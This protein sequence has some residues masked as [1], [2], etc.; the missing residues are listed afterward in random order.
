MS[1]SLNQIN[2]SSSFDLISNDETA[3]LRIKEDINFTY[4]GTLIRS[5]RYGLAQNLLHKINKPSDTPGQW[6]W[7]CLRA[8]LMVN[9]KE[10]KKCKQYLSDKISDRKS[11]EDLVS[12]L[13]YVMWEEFL[14][15][16]ESTVERSLT[17]EADVVKED[18]AK[19]IFSESSEDIEEIVPIW[20]FKNEIHAYN[21]QSSVEMFQGIALWGTGDKPAFIVKD[22][23]EENRINVLPIFL[24]E[25]INRAIS[26]IGLGQVIK[27]TSFFDNAVI[28]IFHGRKRCLGLMV[29]DYFKCWVESSAIESLFKK[30]HQDVSWPG[31]KE[32]DR[33]QSI[34]LSKNSNLCDCLSF[35][36]GKEGIISAALF[37]N[38]GFIICLGVDS[39][40]CIM[41]DSSILLPGFIQVNAASKRRTMVEFENLWTFS[42]SSF[43]FLQNIK[44]CTLFIK[45]A[46]SSFDGLK[47]IID[48]CLSRITEIFNSWDAGS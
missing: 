28:Q 32:P 6:I 16:G 43:F 23:E 20:D 10:F 18:E 39:E 3:D 4:L 27:S 44:D 19:E 12:L 46:K 41:Q 13:Q 33:N 34:S 17:S 24:G 22:R 25:D 38:E 8:Q 9:Q 21:D 45:G 36:G 15:W 30:T 26:D 14:H 37:D 1:E 2:F 7:V 40:G 11:D 42:D 35:L 48:Q 5:G 29:K 47:P 31:I